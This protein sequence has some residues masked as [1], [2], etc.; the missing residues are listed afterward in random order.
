MAGPVPHR[1]LLD[2]DTLSDLVGNP[3]G[4][5]ARMI[6]R[7]GED[8]VAT[9]VVVAAELR[10]GAVKRQSSRLSARLDAL[11]REIAVLPLEPGIEMHYAEIRVALER[12]GRSIGGNDMLIAAHALAAD[13]VLVTGNLREFRRVPM[14]EV[15]DWM[16]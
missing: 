13:L 3:H 8:S 7:R 1:Y 6:A 16:S 4:A 5:V 2:S 12:A 14:L 10:Y 9:S 15:V 11:F